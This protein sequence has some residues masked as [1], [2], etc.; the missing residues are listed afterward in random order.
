MTTIRLTSDMRKD[1]KK[2]QKIY[3]EKGIKLS[4]NG[5][6]VYLLIHGINKV[7]AG[8]ALTAIMK[9]GDIEHE[10]SK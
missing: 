6:I 5:T 3:K 7:E 9:E 2:I 10:I 8:Q 1:I 4:L